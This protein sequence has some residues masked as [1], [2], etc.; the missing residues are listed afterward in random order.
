MGNNLVYVDNLVFDRSSFDR[1]YTLVDGHSEQVII[2]FTD[3]KRTKGPT[4]MVGYGADFVSRL[5]DVLKL[6]HIKNKF[7]WNPFVHIDH[8]IFKKRQFQGIEVVSS[9]ASGE[10]VII[11]LKD[12]TSLTGKSFMK[13]CTS[14]WVQKVYQAVK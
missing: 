12:G 8:L 13:G 3:G 1:A 7:K 14:G 4:T 5:A 2:E 10:S 9:G 11:H 6:S